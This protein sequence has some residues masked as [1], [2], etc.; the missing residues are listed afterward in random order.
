MNSTGISIQ[1]L[2]VCYGPVE[3]LSDVSLD[4]AEG[5]IHILIGPSGCG[6]STLLKA[7]AGIVSPVSGTIERR[8]QALSGIAGFGIGYVPQHYGLLAWK[9]ARA[10][11]F[12]PLAVGAGKN[13]PPAPETADILRILGLEP[14]LH[15]YPDELSG[16][17]KQRVALARALISRPDLLLLDEPFSALDAFTAASSQE[18]FLKL[19]AARPVTTLLITHSLYEAASLGRH[20]LL[21]HPQTRSLSAHIINEHFP[22][23]DEEEKATLVTRLRLMFRQMHLPEDHNDPK[24]HNDPGDHCD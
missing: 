16:G 11:I 12:L 3:A 18:L 24:D 15:R 19:W 9:N 10:N 4:L 1:G 5:E 21:L 8:G 13:S 6:K 20:I 14:L 22:N 17:E 23:D 7:I 2:K